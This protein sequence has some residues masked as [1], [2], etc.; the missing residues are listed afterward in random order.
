MFI[1]DRKPDEGHFADDLA[2]DALQG[3]EKVSAIIDLALSEPALSPRE[4]AVKYTD[5][6]RYY[7]SESTVY[8]LLKASGPDRRSDRS[9]SSVRID[10]HQR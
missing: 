8:R 5:T 7:V 1:I 10:S 9:R 3:P 6:Y 2:D 4:L